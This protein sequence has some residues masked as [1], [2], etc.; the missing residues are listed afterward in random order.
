MRKDRRTIRHD[1]ANGNFSHFYERAQNPRYCGH[2]TT[3]PIRIVM[4]SKAST[5]F[6]LSNT[7]NVSLNPKQAMKARHVCV[8]NILC[9]RTR[10]KYPHQDAQTKTTTDPGPEGS[11]T[12]T[13]ERTLIFVGQTG[14]LL[15]TKH[16]CSFNIHITHNLY[17][18]EYKVSNT[19]LE[20]NQQTTPST[21]D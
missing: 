20:F 18:Y 4:Q 16:H 17:D 10:T 14:Y 13:Q 9:S 8:C 11:G 19:R 1:E 3:K 15:R 21:A 12:S 5:V 7:M 2:N 6:Y